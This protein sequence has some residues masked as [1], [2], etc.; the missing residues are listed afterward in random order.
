MAADSRSKRDGRHLEVLG[1]YNPLPGM[2]YPCPKVQSFV[3]NFPFHDKFRCL[4]KRYMFLLRLT[5]FVFIWILFL[6]YLPCTKTS[7]LKFLSFGFV[8]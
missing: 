8:C 1:Y 7:F 3:M 2:P 5:L 4:L 6:A